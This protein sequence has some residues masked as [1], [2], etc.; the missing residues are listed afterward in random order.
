METD[1]NERWINKNEIKPRR[2]DKKIQQQT[3]KQQKL[4]EIDQ[5][6]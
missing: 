6:N 1:L 2:K 3:K 5:I 4:D